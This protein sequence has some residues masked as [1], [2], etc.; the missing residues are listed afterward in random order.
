MP[1]V[2]RTGI[3]HKSFFC[4]QNEVF[5]VSLESSRGVLPYKK[6][7]ELNGANLLQWKLGNACVVNGIRT[8]EPSEWIQ[9]S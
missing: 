4:D 2:T 7:L 1:L 9:V 6:E 3:N 5:L 8:L